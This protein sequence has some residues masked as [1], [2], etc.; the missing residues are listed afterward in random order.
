MRYIHTPCYFVCIYRAP[1]IDGSTLA[2][3]QEIEVARADS[4]IRTRRFAGHILPRAR[5]D[6]QVIAEN[7]L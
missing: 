3:R 1:G 5:G 7:G 4:Y 2:A 6:W